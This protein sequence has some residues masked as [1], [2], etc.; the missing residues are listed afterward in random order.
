MLFTVICFQI[1]YE[2]LFLFWNKLPDQIISNLQMK[3]MKRLVQLFDSTW[4][5][6]KY[7]IKITSKFITRF[8]YRNLMSSLLPFPIKARFDS[9]CIPLLKMARHKNVK[10]YNAFFRKNCMFHLPQF[11]LTYDDIIKSIL[12]SKRWDNY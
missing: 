6:W 2:Q 11:Q 8:V 7:H 5:Y 4:I 1:S 9:T 3:I 12:Y 10:I